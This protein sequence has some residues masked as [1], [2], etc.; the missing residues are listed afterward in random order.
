MVYLVV[1]VD[2]ATRRHLISALYFQ[3]DF[4]PDVFIPELFIKKGKPHIIH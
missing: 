3:G 4:M 1:Q 2:V